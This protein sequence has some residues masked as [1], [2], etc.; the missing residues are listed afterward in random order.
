MLLL[1]DNYDSFVH[2]LARYLAELGQP[3]RVVRNDR[4]DL[5]DVARWNPAA[6]LLSPGPC[7][8]LEAGHSLELVRRFRGRIPMLG[9]CLGHQTLAA[10]LGGRII[11][12]PEPVH[13]RSSWVR[14]QTSPLFD[15]VANPFLAGRY[16]S[17]IIDE[18]TLPAEFTITARTSDGLPMAIEQPAEQLYGVQ[19]HPESILTQFG[20]QLLV[21]FL[22]LAGID[23]SRH[24]QKS[25][26]ALSSAA[27]RE[28]VEPALSTADLLAD[29]GSNTSPRRATS[30][31]TPLR[32][33][34]YPAALSAPPAVPTAWSWLPSE[35]AEESP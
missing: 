1:I 16:H 34:A 2:N 32:P 33:V 28:L 22:R 9:V 23:V 8:P 26:S 30:P 25:A 35:S 7:T 20:H 5:D 14:H 19:F 13:G 27:H 17:L 15:G 10:A 29:P 6:I 12:A 11:R 3:T 31:A 21:N 24:G 4:F 18:A